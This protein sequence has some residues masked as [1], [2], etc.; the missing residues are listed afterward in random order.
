M[1]NKSIK[2]N[3]IYN[4]S[5]QILLLLTP[6]VTT[7]YISRVLHA[8]GIGAVSFAES[9][10]SYFVLF[11]GL[12][13]SILGQREVSYLQDDKEKRSKVFWNIISIRTITTVL[14]LSLY[15][16]FILIYHK[17]ILMYLLFMINILAVLFDVTFILQGME[18]FGTIVVRNF[19]FKILS[20]KLW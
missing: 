10:V 8:E 17:N 7:P 16:G 6:L 20:I 1:A 2:K 14:C 13:T 9:I 3:Y 4:L 12:G 5:Y 18:E 11:A 15:I 19:I